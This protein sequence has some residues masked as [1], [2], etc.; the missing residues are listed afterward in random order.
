MTKLLVTEV[1]DGPGTFWIPIPRATLE[2]LGWSDKDQLRFEIPSY[3][4]QSEKWLIL[5][6]VEV[7]ADA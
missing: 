4:F 2:A 6:K 1:G 7:K 5:S 3:K